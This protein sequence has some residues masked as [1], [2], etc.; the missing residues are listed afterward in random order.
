MFVHRMC[1]GACC[2]V[3][4]LQCQAS[5]TDPIISIDLVGLE[6]VGGLDCLLDSM[7]REC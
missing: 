1:E 6:D 3:P 5:I 4:F 2:F 7:L